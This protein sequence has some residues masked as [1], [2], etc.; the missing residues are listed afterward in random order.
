MDVGVTMES[1]LKHQLR[2]KLWSKRQ[3]GVRNQLQ[4]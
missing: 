4:N 2:S 3:Y 1:P